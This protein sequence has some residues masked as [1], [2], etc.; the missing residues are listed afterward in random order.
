M[1]RGFSLRQV[2]REKGLSSSH[3]CHRL[4]E[5]SAWESDTTPKP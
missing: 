5:L 1:R 2:L 3:A 4:A